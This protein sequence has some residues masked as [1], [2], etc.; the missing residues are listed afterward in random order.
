M[1]SLT[2][3]D[4]CASA[5]QPAHVPHHLFSHLHLYFHRAQGSF[6]PDSQHICALTLSVHFENIT[7]WTQSCRDTPRQD[8]DD[9]A[10]SLSPQTVAEMDAPTGSLLQ[11]TPGLPR[12]LSLLVQV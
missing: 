5:S 1:S 8:K 6:V 3:N 11:E 10:G 4:N 2:T 7:V 12:T 9:C